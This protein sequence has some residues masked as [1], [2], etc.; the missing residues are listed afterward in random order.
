MPTYKKS[1]YKP[2]SAQDLA[3]LYLQLARLEESGIPIMKA[4]TLLTQDGGEMG[5]RVAV[6]LEHLKRGKSLAEAGT[7]AGLFVGLDTALVKVAEAGGTNAVVFRQLAKFYEDKARR[8]RQIKSQLFLPLTILL[9]AVFI[10]PV[11][12]LLLGKMTAISYL[13]ATVGLIFQMAILIFVLLR[14][15]QW[16]RHGFLRSFRHS[17]E[18]AEINLPYLG[19]WYVRR[20]LRDFM[21]SL[22][23]MLQAGLPILEALPKAYEVVENLIIRQRLQKITSHL[24][25]GDSF[26]NAFSQVEGVNNIAS[27]LVL[28]GEYAGSLAEIMLHY[29]KLES[30]DIARHD[31]M[32]AIWIPRIIYAGIIAWM[33]YGILNAWAPTAMVNGE[34]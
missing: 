19:K 26:A 17:W 21:R 6:A 11:P 33:A 28:T 12:A 5:K 8:V 2:L 16:I 3:N 14:L 32:L 27:Q 25:D 34:W 29:V 22:G 20:S 24:R 7:R 1:R 4:L 30:E 13:G 31:E 23:L 18:R 10:Q 15:P 9:L